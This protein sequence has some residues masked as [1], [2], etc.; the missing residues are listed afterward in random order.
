MIKKIF[1]IFFSFLLIIKNFLLLKLSSF[2]KINDKNRLVL[3]TLNPKE[4]D[5]E[6]ACK[7]VEKITKKINLD[8]CLLKSLTKYELLLYFGYIPSLYIGVKNDDGFYSHSWTECENI[9]CYE[10]KDTSMHVIRKIG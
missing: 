5:V 7:Y 10:K 9:N 3:F 4:F 1:L 8:T 6:L 2:S